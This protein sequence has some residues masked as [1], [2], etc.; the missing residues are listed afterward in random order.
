LGLRAALYLL[1][2]LCFSVPG[3]VYAGDGTWESSVGALALSDGDTEAEEDDDDSEDSEDESQADLGEMDSSVAES[4]DAAD[5]VPLE[6]WDLSP[7]ELAELEAL[8]ALEAS[9]GLA[10]THR[11]Q[12]LRRKRARRA[13]RAIHSVNGASAHSRWSLGVRGTGLASLRKDR[14]V[15]GLGGV[16]GFVEFS[17]VHGEL[18]LELASRALFEEG[19]LHVPVE[20]LFKRPW[21]RGDFRFFIGVGP[22]VI[23]GAPLGEEDASDGHAA[24]DSEAAEA[25]PPTVH[26]GFSGLA[27]LVWWMQPR[28]GLSAELNYNIVIDHGASHEL[29]A[30]VGVV[31][32]L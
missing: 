14:P 5:A 13:K 26:F 27:G 25:A 12:M 15:K 32:G 3:A 17:A 9:D 2:L 7:Q 1:F 24:E 18:E 16:G 29:G 11:I 31:F 28:V 4:G 20:L 30:S 10:S 22:A 23:F 6:N 8:E 21:E 19:E